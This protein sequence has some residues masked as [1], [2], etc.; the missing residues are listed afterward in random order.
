M[1]ILL[2]VNSLKTGL[3]LAS[4]GIRVREYDDMTA[5][6]VRT[7][8]S[9][10]ITRSDDHASTEVS[11]PLADSEIPEQGV[12]PLS[13]LTALEPPTPEVPEE[14]ADTSGGDYEVCVDANLM[15]RI[16]PKK[17]DAEHTVS[18]SPH[19]NTQRVSLSNGS[20]CSFI[21]PP[22]KKIR[23]PNSLP[24]G[25][26]ELHGVA[27][28]LRATAGFAGQRKDATDQIIITVTE[29]EKIW[30]SR[31]SGVAQVAGH[32]ISGDPPVNI[33]RR[34]LLRSELSKLFAKENGDGLG[35]SLDIN[36]GKIYG[37][38]N[39]KDYKVRYATTPDIAGSVSPPRIE[40]WLSA[41]PSISFSVP[42]DRFKSGCISACAVA[43]YAPS[44][45]ETRDISPISSPYE[46]A[47]TEKPVAQ[48][49]CRMSFKDS[50]D[51]V[52]LSS[53]G[54]RYDRAATVL[55]F[56]E[57]PVEDS[58]SQYFPQDEWEITVSSTLLAVTA[59]SVCEDSDVRISMRTVDNV[60]G[61]MIEPSDSSCFVLPAY[62]EIEDI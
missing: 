52:I 50:S 17:M 47:H 23:F 15:F 57:K 29:E 49:L 14:D 51:R 34:V 31:G 55:P 54:W 39:P 30:L 1:S 11:I 37:E 45:A 62:P 4:G 28:A 8:K 25:A 56:I 24:F 16:L 18:I 7:D 21:S 42:G 35:F 3:I 60:E 58:V 12:L 19:H 27:Q 48:K 13:V 10:T 20:Y 22:N 40:K 5:K 38:L 9:I 26:T 36:T 2:P 53:H 61:M 43:G 44:T 46:D 6:L 32:L 41:E 33:G 59:A